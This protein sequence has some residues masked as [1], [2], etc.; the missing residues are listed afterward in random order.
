MKRT[1]ILII[2]FVFVLAACKKKKDS[3]GCYLCQR[4][5]TI[6][7]T[8]P[9]FAKP[10]TLVAVDTLCGRTDGW[11]QLYVSQHS[12]YDTTKNSNDTIIFEDHAVNCGLQ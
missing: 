11:M 3:T 6:Y 9:V 1:L 8:L 2:A 4:Y 5:L 12:Y 10:Q 7:S